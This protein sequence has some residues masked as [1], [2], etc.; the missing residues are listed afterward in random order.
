MASKLPQSDIYSLLGVKHTYAESTIRKAYR[1]LV[2]ALE[3][4]HGSDYLKTGQYK[5]YE[6]AWNV[7][8][9]PDAR[10]GYDAY[11]RKEYGAAAAEAEAAAKRT[12]VRRSSRSTKPQAEVHT[13]DGENYRMYDPKLPA[14][15]YERGQVWYFPQVR[16]WVNKYALVEGYGKVMGVD[17]FEG[18]NGEVGFVEIS[19]HELRKMNGGELGKDLRRFITG[20]GA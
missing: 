7:V 9:D 2:K 3:A 13:R 8:A 5:A 20:Q 19:F 14:S 15:I 10:A 6:E 12:T 1:A 4:E 17:K 18:I 11:W 16:S